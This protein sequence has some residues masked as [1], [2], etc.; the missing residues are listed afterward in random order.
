MQ[1]QRHKIYGQS[2][3]VFTWGSPKK[4]PIFMVHGWLDTGASFHFLAEVLK[5]DFYCIALDMRGYGKSSHAKDPLGYFFM[6]YVADLKALID[7]FFPKKDFYLMGHS[8]GGAVTSVYAAAFPE[9]LK[10]L[11]NLEGFVFRKHP[12]RGPERRL[13]QWMDKLE[14]GLSFPTHPSLAAFA[15]RLCQRYVRFDKKRALFFAK[16]LTKKVPGGYKM[17]ADPSHQVPEPYTILP[18]VYYDYWKAIKVPC[19]FVVAE[20]SEMGTWAGISWKAFI[21]KQAKYFPPKTQLLWVPDCG[22]MIPHEQPEFLAERVLE[23]L[24]GE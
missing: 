14:K 3:R 1:I 4:P 21:K 23:F 18:E 13:R 15:D 10:K 12:D 2:L 22:H 6:Q 11:I 5:K 8:L 9:R 16:H 24:R 17:A 20:E 7:D 19:L